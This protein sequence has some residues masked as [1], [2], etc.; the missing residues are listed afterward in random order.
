MSA[1]PSTKLQVNFSTPDRTLINIYADDGPELAALLD[2][3]GDVASKVT[4]TGALFS[5]VSAVQPIAQQ[6]T[7]AQPQQAAYGAA[8]QAQAGPPRPAQPEFCAHGEMSWKSGIAKASGNPYGVWECP[9]GLKPPQG[10]ES[11]WPKRGR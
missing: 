7:Q 8:A 1:L 4:E 2:E 10:C 3:L 6:S 9:T 11:K 5:A